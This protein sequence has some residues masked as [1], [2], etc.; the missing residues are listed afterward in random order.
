MFIYGSMR[1]LSFRDVDQT[2]PIPVTTLNFVKRAD[3]VNETTAKFIPTPQKVA[4]VCCGIELPVTTKHPRDATV[5]KL[6]SAGS[7]VRRLTLTEGSKESDDP[8]W[9]PDGERKCPKATFE[10]SDGSRKWMTKEPPLSMSGRL[11]DTLVAGCKRY[12][13]QT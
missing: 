6:H 4:T 8:A 1:L 9:S 7:N 5:V 11:G 2:A 10:I 3:V 12:A 13:F